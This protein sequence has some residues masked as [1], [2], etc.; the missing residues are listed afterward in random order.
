MNNPL[1]FLVTHETHSLPWLVSRL[2]VRLTRSPRFRECACSVGVRT[3]AGAPVD[4]SSH[5][6]L[7]SA[8][9]VFWAGPLLGG[10]L[11]SGLY[12]VAFRAARMGTPAAAPSDEK[13]EKYLP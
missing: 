9:Q 7:R 4:R 12:S 11:A 8:L 1:S 5:A 2:G 3:F 10:L 13:A 6:C